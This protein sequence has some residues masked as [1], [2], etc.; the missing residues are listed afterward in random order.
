MDIEAYGRLAGQIV[1]LPAD[2]L[3][4]RCR[5][6][7][8]PVDLPGAR[9]LEV[10][11]GS[12]VL[13]GYALQAGADEVVAIEPEAAGSTEGYLSNIRQLAD[14]LADARLRVL[15]CTLQDFDGPGPFDAVVLDDSI[16]HLDEPACEVLHRDPAAREVYL[17]LFGRLR[18]LLRPGGDL[19]IC[20]CARRNAW[21]D[22]GLR[23]PICGS[24]EWQKHQQ[25][26]LWAKLLG[27]AGLETV[28][29]R[30]TPLYRLA[31]L[32]RLAGNAAVSYFLTSHFRLHARRPG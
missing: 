4:H 26:A 9:L 24:I 8:G 1:N 25:P 18:E 15:P 17:H 23:N 27:Q 13:S 20:D 21:A 30:W 2:R 10:G 14:T 22:L 29:V 12:G 19:V 5:W 16:N 11:A 32:G 6:V 7:L 28:A 31:R 3:L